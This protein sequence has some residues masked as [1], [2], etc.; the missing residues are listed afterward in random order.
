MLNLLMVIQEFGLAEEWLK[1]IMCCNQLKKFSNKL[2]VNI[3]ETRVIRI[4][5]RYEIIGFF[6]E[7]VLV[8][9]RKLLIPFKY[10]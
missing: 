5:G 2:I 1:R 4:E 9:T 3:M 7:G 6:Q 10:R 8:K